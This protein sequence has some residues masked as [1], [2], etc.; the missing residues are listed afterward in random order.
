MSK[1][2]S[3]AAAE[4]S[5]ARADKAAQ[6]AATAAAGAAAGDVA[7]AL[8]AKD[9][10]A[11]ASAN[12]AAAVASAKDP[13]A[14]DAQAAA[15]A[16]KAEKYAKQAESQLVL[17]RRAAKPSIAKKPSLTPG[18]G[19]LADALMK[20]P[21]F[22]GHGDAK[23]V[24]KAILESRNFDD[25]KSMDKLEQLWAWAAAQEGVMGTPLEAA[26]RRVAKPLADVYVDATVLPDAAADLRADTPFAD[27]MAVGQ[28][29]KLSELRPWQQLAV[30]V[31]YCDASS[32][33]QVVKLR[34]LVLETPRTLV[35]SVL[36]MTSDAD[37]FTLQL[38]ALRSML[39]AWSAVEA[40]QATELA[41]RLQL[42]GKV[43]ARFVSTY[44]DLSKTVLFKR[45]NYVI[46]CL[47]MREAQADAQMDG[48][49][50]ARLQKEMIELAMA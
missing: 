14:T 2:A 22:A 23:A 39:A 15:A 11:K 38:A 44:L 21:K 28:K 9:A 25:D 20:D 10:A 42:D 6:D 7:A 50:L 16:V 29:R 31:A 13:A 27:M 34:K 37:D 32:D 24:M 5:A 46:A 30:L 35:K 26:F 49:D 17:A 48:A 43:D 18:I 8:T 3:I 47:K 41:K 40:A 19:F 12:A 33:P 4:A 36:V 45:I 1:Q